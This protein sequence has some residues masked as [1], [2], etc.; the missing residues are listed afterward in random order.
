MLLL[1]DF[2]FKTISQGAFFL[3]KKH[4][5]KLSVGVFCGAGTTEWR[6]HSFQRA[7]IPSINKLNVY[8]DIDNTDK[9]HRYLSFIISLH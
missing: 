5:T 9:L 4:N 2:F 6:F 8:H 3:T 1:C 7:N